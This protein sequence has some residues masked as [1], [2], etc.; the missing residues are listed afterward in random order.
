M[1]AL[2]NIYANM[3][4]E[5]RVFGRP[6]ISVDIQPSYRPWISDRL[7]NDY[8]KFL[9]NHKGKI[10]FLFNGEEVGID[11]TEEDIKNWLYE[12]GID[13]EKIETIQFVEKG[14]GFFRS[15]MDAGIDE[16][17]IQKAIRYM[18]SNGIFSSEDIPDEDRSQFDW[19]ESMDSDPI[20]IPHLN[21]AELYALQPC[22][23]CGGGRQECLWEIEILLRA[24]NIKT[25]RIKHLIY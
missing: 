17:V 8:I 5:R 11:D 21:V 15:W 22:Y 6:L 19:E 9:Q 14:Y 16:A 2:T 13:I 20:Y 4:L 23:I 12:G 7:F 10:Y 1:D 24:F 25:K 18:F 3:L